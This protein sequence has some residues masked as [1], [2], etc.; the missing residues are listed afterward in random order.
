MK[1]TLLG[2]AMVAAIAL[3]VLTSCGQTA[4]EA[5][6]EAKDAAAEVAEATEEAIE[7]GA[8]AVYT[9]VLWRELT[10]GPGDI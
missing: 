5:V 4:E 2:L 10:V 3:L 8:E 1:K 9:R 7:E 6:D